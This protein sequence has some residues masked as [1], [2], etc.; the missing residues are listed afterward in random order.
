M[1]GKHLRVVEHKHVVFVELIDNFLKNMVFDFAGFGIQHHQAR[2]V[3]MLNGILSNL[4][5]GQLKLKLR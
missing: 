2:F 4:L 5:F 1:R 3:A